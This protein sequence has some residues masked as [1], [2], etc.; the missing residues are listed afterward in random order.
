MVPEE[1]IKET[2]TTTPELAAAT[3]KL[4]ELANVAGGRDNI[5]LILARISV[6]TQPA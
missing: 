4:V 6:A 3:S 2:L 5:T 1:Q